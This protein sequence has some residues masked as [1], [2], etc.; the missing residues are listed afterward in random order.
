MRR[1]HPNR[2]PYALRVA[3]HANQ[4]AVMQAIKP[5]TMP[6]AFVMAIG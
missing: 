1:L 5:K 6:G 4:S 3:D 2:R